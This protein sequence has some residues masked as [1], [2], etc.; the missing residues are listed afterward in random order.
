M[1]TTHTILVIEDD[2][3][4]ARLLRMY[5]EAEHYGV[6]LAHDGQQGLE[7]ALSTKP[8]LI[9]LDLMLPGLDGRE[10]CATLRR[11]A[12]LRQETDLAIIMLTARATEDDLLHGLEL[13]AD[14]YIT[15]PFSPREVVAR[16]RTVLRR[17]S[18][19]PRPESAEL[20]Y[21]SLLID[22]Q[23]YRVEVNGEPIEL[24]PKEFKLLETL[25]KTPG[26]VFTRDALIE[27]AFGY[28][29]EGMARTVDAHIM[30]LRRKIEP[31]PANPTYIQTV[32]GVGYRFMEASNAQ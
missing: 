10:V 2:V 13:G 6:L 23:R 25:A 22:M 19:A 9:L 31:D 17:T 30:N 14:D 29:Y 20:R 27:K 28:D 8:D 12:A 3:K 18:R 11:E 32:Y 4:T 16:V 7:L 1:T 15:K 24:T 26:Y 21:G 5:L